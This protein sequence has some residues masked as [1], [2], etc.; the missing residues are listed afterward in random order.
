MI[1]VSIGNAL[2]GR[3]FRLVQRHDQ[4]SGD[5]LSFL[6]LD[7]GDE[8]LPLVTGVG[9]YPLDRLSQRIDKERLT[10]PAG[11]DLR[12]ARPR[13]VSNKRYIRNVSLSPKAKRVALEFRG[14]I[15]TVP[16]E[17]GDPRN[18]TQTTGA[19]DRSP[20]WSPDGSQ[21]AWLS[22]ASGEYALYIGNQDGSGES[23]VIELDGTG[24]YETPKWSPDG[25]HL[26][27]RDNSHSLY[28]LEVESGKATKIAREA[29]RINRDYFYAT[30]LSRSGLGCG[31]GEVRAFP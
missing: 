13:Y 1:V 5:A 4:T 7:G 31:L 24:F 6:L 21:I 14:E 18:L 26:S 10:V 29:W 23:R 22:D 3:A 19:H 17:K 28:V 8:R 11:A 15:V 20:V 30:N 9:Q 25:K 16:A 2:R 27:Y 12:E